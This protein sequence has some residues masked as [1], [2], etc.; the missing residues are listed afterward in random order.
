MIS[1]IDLRTWGIP[2]ISAAIFVVVLLYVFARKRSERKSAEAELLRHCLGDAEMAERLI[3]FE[4][5]RT[6]GGSREAAAR[7]AT[8]SNRRDNK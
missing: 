8:H 2:L 5:K 6:K 7:A 3:A 4:Q 1:E